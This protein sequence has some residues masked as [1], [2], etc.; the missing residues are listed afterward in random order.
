MKIA[1]EGN[2]LFTWEGDEAAIENILQ[3]VP[4]AAISQQMSPED[5]AYNSVLHLKAGKL[6]TP[7]EVGREMQMM[8]VVWFFLQLETGSPDHAV[9]WMWKL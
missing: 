8:C 2:P 3:A 5:L 6:L 1:V 7:N 4:D 9:W